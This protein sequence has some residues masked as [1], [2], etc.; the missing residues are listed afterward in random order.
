MH[1]NENKAK[2]GATTNFVPEQR[3]NGMFQIKYPHGSMDKFLSAVTFE[4]P[5]FRRKVVIYLIHR[6]V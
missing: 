6:K 5:K 2:Q 1:N 3:G 4:N